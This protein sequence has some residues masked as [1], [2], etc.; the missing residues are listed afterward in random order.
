MHQRLRREVEALL[1]ELRPYFR[2][3]R[4][5]ILRTEGQEREHAVHKLNLLATYT[6]KRCVLFLKSEESGTI[7][8]EELEMAASEICSALRAFHVHAAITGGA[9]GLRCTGDIPRRGGAQ[10]G[11]AGGVCDDGREERDVPRG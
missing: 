8:I 5:E 9:S 2:E 7:A 11:R 1:E 6:K 3:F 4:E 10:P